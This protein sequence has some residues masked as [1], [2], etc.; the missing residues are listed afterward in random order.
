MKRYSDRL[1]IVIPCYNDH[2]YV[3]EAVNSAL[4][5]T[6]SQ[7]EVIVVDDGSNAQTKAVLK[8]LE[9]KIDLLITQENRGVSAARNNGIKAANGKYI[10]VLDSDDYFEPEFCAK[11][12]EIIKKDK[13]IKVVT[14][15]TQ[16]LLKNG[17][18][19]I[20]KP[21]GGDISKFILFN[22]AVGSALFKK[23]DWY[24]SG[25]YD[26]D[27]KKGWEDWEFYIRLHKR[28]G[29]TFVIPEV[30]FNYRKKEKSKT[31]IANQNKYELMKY[32]YLKH[33]DL[34]K[35]YYEDFIVFWLN[36]YEQ[37]EKYKHKITRSLEFKIGS[38]VAKS[39]RLLGLFKK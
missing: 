29:Y 30:L 6:Y 31:T 3:E 14:C 21:A 39:L 9:P 26:E 33:A 35:R 38:K 32:I 27:L 8:K 28:G 18:N 1:S 19:E 10:L 4:N 12:F 24:A 36:K 22:A 5:Q 16:L 37:Q 7:K 11:A 17:E 25:Q 23:E 13:S 34:Y 2:L 15:H 20:Y